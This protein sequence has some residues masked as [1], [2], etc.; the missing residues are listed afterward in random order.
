MGYKIGDHLGSPSMAAFT[1]KKPRIQVSHYLKFS[2]SAVLV[3]CWR[4]GRFLSTCFDISKG[5]GQQQQ[6]SVDELATIMWRK[7]K[8]S[9]TFP[10]RPVWI[11]LPPGDAA[12]IL[13]VFQ[14]ISNLIKKISY[15]VPLSLSFSEFQS[16]WRL[17]LTIKGGLYKISYVCLGMLATLYHTH[18]HGLNKIF[19]M[20][21]FIHRVNIIRYRNLRFYLIKY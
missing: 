12:P 4:P 21:L 7:Q 8:K 19:L 20:L 5:W 16:S 6:Y 14:A 11:R 3:W 17:R 9:N 1:L 10:R 15:S 2:V 18:I 13:G